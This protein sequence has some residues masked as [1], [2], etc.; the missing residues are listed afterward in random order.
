MLF[1]GVLR[2]Q[3]K[4]LILFTLVLWKRMRPQTNYMLFLR[5]KLILLKLNSDWIA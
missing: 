3:Q 2:R 4:L 5:R 1:Y